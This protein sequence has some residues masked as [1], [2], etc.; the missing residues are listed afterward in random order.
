MLAQLDDD[1]NEYMVACASRS[2]NIHERNYTPWKGELLAVVWAIKTFRVYLHG[3]HFEL[4]TDHRPLLWL[5]NQNEPTGQHARWVLSLMEY[6]FHVR[7]RAGVDHVNADVLSR[8]PELGPE[9][10]SG[11]QLDSSSDPVKARLPQVVFG[12]VGTGTPADFPVEQIP[13]EPLTPLSVRPPAQPPAADQGGP[14]SA[15]QQAP[16]SAAQPK[17]HRRRQ[18]KAQ[19]RKQHASPYAAAASPQWEAFEAPVFAMALNVTAAQGR[20]A[21]VQRQ[22]ATANSS[23]VDSYTFSQWDPW[24]LPHS[25]QPDPLHGV[26][27]QPWAA[28]QQQQLR[29]KASS[30]VAAAAQTQQP[31]QQRLAAQP[32]SQPSRWLTPSFRP[33]TLGWW[34]LNHLGGCV[35]ASRWS[36]ATG[37]QFQHIFIVILTLLPTQWPGTGCSSCR[38]G[39]L[40]SYQPQPWPLPSRPSRRTSGRSSPPSCKPF[41]PVISGSGW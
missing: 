10:G 19:F 14:S 37:V 16:A 3:V 2:L 24:E 31:A 5:L 1:G 28:E 11:A 22:V 27:V 38:P 23:P 4:C 8:Y 17:Q 32:A 13:S 41:L 18:T 9:D 40:A 39:I 33:Q 34:F 29:R 30:W 7:H 20:A 25:Q 21:F 36:C 12:P 15:V 35:Q 6:D 26:G